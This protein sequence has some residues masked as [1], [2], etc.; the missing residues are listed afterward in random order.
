VSI[1]R[2]G[3]ALGVTRQAARKVAA[4]LERRGFAVTTRD[5]RDARQVNL[6]LTPEGH[7]Y[8]QAIVTVIER[9]NQ[10][11]S[12]RVRPAD[13]AAAD[14][15]LRAVLTDTRAR[16]LAEHLPRPD[17]DEGSAAEV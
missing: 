13:L 3:H 1:G 5:A 10:D 8:A 15:V 7:A 2:L 4:G 11:L 12:R 17:G 9:M 14:T 16:S 6:S